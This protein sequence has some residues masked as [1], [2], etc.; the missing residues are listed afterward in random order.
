MTLAQAMSPARK[1][2][3]LTWVESRNGC[4]VTDFAPL[5]DLL[6]EH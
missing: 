5:V 3:G 6:H 1:A 4:R 2:H